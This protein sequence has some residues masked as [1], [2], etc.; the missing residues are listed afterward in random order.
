MFSQILVPVDGSDDGWVA[1]AQAVALAR[2]E[3]S[4]IQGLYVGDVRLIE[5][6][7]W[8]APAD[9]AASVVDAATMDTAVK[10]SQQ[11]AA[12][13]Q[14][15]LS[16]LT[17]TCEEA[18]VVCQTHYA[19]GVVSQVIL[20]YAR[21]SDLVVMGR[22]GSSVPWIGPL[23][24]STF[25]AVV[26]HSP[27]PVLA[28][29]SEIRPMQRILVAYDGSDRAKQALAVAAHLAQEREDRSL[30]LLVVADDK[31]HEWETI[32]RQGERQ[33]QQAGVSAK[34]IFYLGEAGQDI[35]RVAREEACDL[36]VMG[37]YGHGR[38][39]EWV[40]GS[41]V[42]EVMRGAACPVLICHKKAPAK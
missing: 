7:Y 14:A 5:A 35:L 16:Q 38:I 34:V 22:Q 8:V 4:V 2:E 20:E 30:V 19:E 37:A 10:L 39:L 33:L 12:E 6:P 41:T 15:A 11:I 27:V 1:L 18:G 17:E 42:E 36:I 31:R 25:E 23:L 40:L 3:N 32:H 26:R 9:M 13:G 24:G 29:Q 28:C 21:Q